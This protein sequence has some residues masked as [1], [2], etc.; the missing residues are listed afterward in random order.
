MGNAS[1]K[2][3]RD[4]LIWIIQ[5]LKL[6]EGWHRDYSPLPTGFVNQI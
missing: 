2:S 4:F 5:G 1:W 3:R 6:K